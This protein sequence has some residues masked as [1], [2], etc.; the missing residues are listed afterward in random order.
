ML[1]F[2][3]FS[4]KY[5]IFLYF[6]FFYFFLLILFISYIFL[7]NLISIRYISELKY[8]SMPISEYF[9]ITTLLSFSGLP[10]FFF[11]FVKYFLI[12][13][14]IINGIAINSVFAILLLFLSWFIYFSSIRYIV[15]AKDSNNQLFCSYSKPYSTFLSIFLFLGFIFLFLGFMFLYDAFIF[16]YYLFV[17]IC[18]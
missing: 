18:Y 16:I 12:S 17:F 14:I 11:F 6:I 15:L 8:S 4:I 13:N 1:I 10:P 7:L 3:I 9:I 5:A 2:N